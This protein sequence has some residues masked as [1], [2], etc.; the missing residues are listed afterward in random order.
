LLY[1]ENVHNVSYKE[2]SVLTYRLWSSGL[3][4]CNIL[5]P[6][7]SLHSVTTQKSVA[8]IFITLKTYSKSV[9]LGEAYRCQSWYCMC[10]KHC[11][12]F[13]Q[14]YGLTQHCDIV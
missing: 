5:R 12:Y 8:C 9:D 6:T 13:T 11:I 1:E 4:C 14:C 7:T 3:W 10:L 2:L